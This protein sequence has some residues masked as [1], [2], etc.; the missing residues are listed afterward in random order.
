MKLS[1][2]EGYNALKACVLD[3]DLPKQYNKARKKAFKGDFSGLDQLQA[4]YPVELLQV[5]RNIV[6]SQFQRYKRA[7]NRT[8]EY[9]K[10]GEGVFITFTFSDQA[11]K[12]DEKTRR[13]YV[14]RCLRD[15]SKDYIANIDYGTKSERE[16]YHAIIRLNGCRLKSKW[17]KVNGKRFL[18][19]FY[20]P[21]CCDENSD[22]WLSVSSLPALARW[23]DNYGFIYCKVVATS[24]NDAKATSRYVSK[25][26]TAH[27]LKRSTKK[28]KVSAPRLIYS[29]RNR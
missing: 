15:L 19:A 7:F 21:V 20:Q 8:N 17:I 29:R 23:K 12:T 26:L 24:D 3:E 14:S 22:D 11:L 27:A 1:H 4:I 18:E 10:A 13:V 28:E 6:S 25:S 16:H 9:I 2:I 5:A